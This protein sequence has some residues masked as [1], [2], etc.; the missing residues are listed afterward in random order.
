MRW[1]HF[2]KN[3][4][5]GPE[6]LWHIW[7]EIVEYSLYTLCPLKNIT[8]WEGQMG[9]FDGEIKKAIIS[10]KSINWEACKS[11]QNLDWDRLRVAK[12]NVRKLIMQ[13]K[14]GY[15]IGKLE[16]FCNVPRKSCGEIHKHLLVGNVKSNVNIQVG[17]PNGEKVKGYKAACEINRYY[18]KVEETLASNFQ[19]SWN[20]HAN[21]GS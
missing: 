5:E 10:K 8:I 3:C 18:S 7:L 16:E 15:V 11:N 17:T 4:I 13:K 1:R 9:W 6:K 12:R 20:I 2:W 19:S 21:L 14:R